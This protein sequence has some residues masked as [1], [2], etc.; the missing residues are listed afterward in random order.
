MGIN[1]VN[2]CHHGI[3]VEGTPPLTLA[4]SDNPLRIIELPAFEEVVDGILITTKA[5]KGLSYKLPIE[6]IDTYYIVPACVASFLIYR[7]DILVPQ[8]L[9]VRNG[10][11]M[12]AK[13]L[14]RW[15]KS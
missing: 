9:I 8:G 13:S 11:I 1:F 2:L 15:I 7:T 4:K 3:N 10:E 5:V 12:G 14:C 6:N